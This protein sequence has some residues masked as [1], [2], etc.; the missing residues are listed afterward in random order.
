M[1]EGNKNF[2]RDP[3]GLPVMPTITEGP[4]IFIYVRYNTNTDTSN[5]LFDNLETNVFEAMALP[6]SGCTR[7]IC[8]PALAKKCQLE[9]DYTEGNDMTGANG[10]TLDC[11]GSTRA[12][13]AYFGMVVP[14]KIF[15][16]RNFS[17]NFFLLSRRVCQA[18]Q[19]L[20]PEF[21]LPVQMCNPKR[22]ANPIVHQNPYKNRGIRQEESSPIEDYALNCVPKH[23]FSKPRQNYFKQKSLV[24]PQFARQDTIV[25]IQEY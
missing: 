25:F 16:M 10:E 23:E 14:I 24:F 8:N 21:P 2:T 4:Q 6:D 9:I 18:L 5:D 20:P 22:L 17:P 3:N 1:I 13:V 19:I 7:T 15:V 12:V 11:I